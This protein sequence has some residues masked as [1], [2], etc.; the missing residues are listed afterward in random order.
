[1][2]APEAVRLTLLPAHT[3]EPAP[4][5]TTVGLLETVIVFIVLL[6]QPFVAVPVTV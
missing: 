3:D 4:E 2:L 5:T 1:V 6:L